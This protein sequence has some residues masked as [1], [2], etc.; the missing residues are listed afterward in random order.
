VGI[1]YKGVV[2]ADDVVFG[3]Q[4]RVGRKIPKHDLPYM[5]QQKETLLCTDELPELVSTSYYLSLD[6]DGW[7]Q[8]CGHH[9]QGCC[10]C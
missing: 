4:L 8:R 10:D 7:D 9:L 1:I 6:P 5:Q 3:S 2:T